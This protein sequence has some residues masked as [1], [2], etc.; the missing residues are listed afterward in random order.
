MNVLA[1]VILDPPSALVFGSVLA[2]LSF[3]KIRLY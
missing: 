1:T 2:V 3:K